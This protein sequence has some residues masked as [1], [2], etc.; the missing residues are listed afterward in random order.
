MSKPSYTVY[1]TPSDPASRVIL[2]N[3]S[4]NVPDLRPDGARWVWDFRLAFDAVLGIARALSK[5]YQCDVTIIDNYTR[6]VDV[7][8]LNPEQ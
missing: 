8:R 5:Q 2:E 1:F 6:A 3:A 7:V 4:D